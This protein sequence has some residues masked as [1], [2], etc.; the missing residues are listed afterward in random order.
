MPLQGQALQGKHSLDSLT[1]EMEA[2]HS[3]KHG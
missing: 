1:L 2:Y 3:S